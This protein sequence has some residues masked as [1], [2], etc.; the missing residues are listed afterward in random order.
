[1]HI[2][3]RHLVLTTDSTVDAFKKYCNY[4]DVL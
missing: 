3:D 2:H 4:T 1:M